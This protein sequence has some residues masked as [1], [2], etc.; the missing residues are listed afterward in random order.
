MVSIN[1]S[2]RVAG[3]DIVEQPSIALPE[4]HP[5][6]LLLDPKK[7]VLVK[8][9]AYQTS[10]YATLDN[11]F[12]EQT[13]SDPGEEFLKSPEQPVLEIDKFD[14]TSIEGEPTFIK[15][16]DPVTGALTY[17]VTL[18]IRNTSN[19]SDNVK[20]VDARIYIPGS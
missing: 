16:Y 17:W 10:S 8:G 9:G 11:P 1:K 15:K 6:L 14:L 19:N 18:K 20:G 5:D 13:P 7:V 4:G 3:Q 2:K 12:L